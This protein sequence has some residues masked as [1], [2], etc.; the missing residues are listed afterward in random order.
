MQK[1]NETTTIQVKRTTQTTLEQL[2]V[3]PNQSYDEVIQMLLKSAKEKE[4]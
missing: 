2:K 4:A 1:E 3:H